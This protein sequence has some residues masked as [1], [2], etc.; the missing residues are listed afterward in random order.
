[1]QTVELFFTNKEYNIN[2]VSEIIGRK[3][4]DYRYYGTYERKNPILIKIF[5]FHKRLKDGKKTLSILPSFILSR[6]QKNPALFMEIVRQISNGSTSIE[7]AWLKYD[8]PGHFRSLKTFQTYMK[9]LYQQLNRILS[10]LQ[11]QIAIHKVDTKVSDIFPDHKERNTKF[12]LLYVLLDELKD[13]LHRK[14]LYRHFLDRE[15]VSFLNH[16]LFQEA[17]IIFLRDTS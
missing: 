10:L 15:T 17:G 8:S 9:S 7:K 5:R 2:S 11:K 4:P 13:T 1:M 6:K 14:G 16:I 12:N 3:Y